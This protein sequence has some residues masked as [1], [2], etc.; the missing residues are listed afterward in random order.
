MGDIEYKNYITDAIYLPH[1][2]QLNEDE[3]KSECRTKSLMVVLIWIL[4]G[5]ITYMVFY[6]IRTE[7]I[8]KTLYRI[9]W[10]ERMLAK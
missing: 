9:F 6:N 4:S 7:K 5:L 1:W 2:K 3:R 8:K 10:V